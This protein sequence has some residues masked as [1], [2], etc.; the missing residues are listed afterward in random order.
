MVLE[1]FTFRKSK[2]DGGA[3]HD[4]A[5]KTDETAEH[6]DASQKGEGAPEQQNVDQKEDVVQQQVAEQHE[7]A[8]DKNLVLNREDEQFLER[9]T[10][11]DEAPPLPEQ[12]TVILE[13]GKKVRG[14]DAQIALMDG[15]DQIPLPS[16][17]GP[18]DEDQHTDKEDE[19]VSEEEKKR[20]DYWSYIPAM[21]SWKV[22]RMLPQSRQSGLTRP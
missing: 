10:S 3:D 15:A 9:I 22:R 11:V 18:E 21:P 2:K 17:P 12:P 13:N 14:K 1:Y 6:Q 5:S 7:E 19:P 4:D 8:T 16:T 20:R